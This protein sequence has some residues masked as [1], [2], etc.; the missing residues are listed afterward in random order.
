MIKNRRNFYRILQVQPDATPEIIR[1]SYRTLM[2]DLK[3]HP[4]LGGSNFSASILNEAYG[5][6]RDSKRRA[7]Y[8]KELSLKNGDLR[9]GR[10]SSR[11][12]QPIPSTHCPFCKGPLNRKLTPGEQCP[13]CFTPVQSDR[14]ASALSGKR[15][16]AR[17]K[18]SDRMFYY[19]AWPGKPAEGHMIDFSPKGMRFLCGEKL[20]SKTV[21]KI[22]TGFLEASATVTNMQEQFSNGRK[23]YS[24]GVRFIAVQFTESTGNL[25]STSA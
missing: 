24:V 1:A 11:Q 20:V 16:L 5:V 17:I 7:A 18:T 8:D 15:A 6:L 19:S 13:I 2:L 10:S 14:T 25:L 3:Q 12:P 22:S 4:D 9:Q 23:N 21:L